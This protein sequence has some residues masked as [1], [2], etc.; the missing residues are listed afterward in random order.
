[1]SSAFD[2]IKRSTLLEIL[3]KFLNEDEMRMI[4]ILL[5]NTTLELKMK[6]TETEM[7]KSNIGS[8]QGDGLSG[9]SFDVYFENSLRKVRFKMISNSALVEHSYIKIK[10]ELISEESIYADDANFMTTEESTK[11]KL[12]SIGYLPLKHL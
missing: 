9:L 6:D 5:S 3:H 12:N 2:T 4:R 10:T 11:T 7:F 1:M 8:P